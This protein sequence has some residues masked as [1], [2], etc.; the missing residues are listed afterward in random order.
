MLV[1]YTYLG[2]KSRSRIDDQRVPT[3]GLSQVANVLI[4][5]IVGEFA[6]EEFLQW[7]PQLNE[8]R[9]QRGLSEHHAQVSR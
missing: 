1:E 3:H 5:R 6:R 9:T 2:N 4:D 7:G 8:L